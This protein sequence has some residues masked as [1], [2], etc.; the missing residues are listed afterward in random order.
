MKSILIALVLNTFFGFQSLSQTSVTIIHVKGA[1]KVQSTG[2]VLLRGMKISDKESLVYGSLNDM[3]AAIHPEK[4]RVIIQPSSKTKTAGS[5]LAYVIKNIYQPMK[6]SA[7]TRGSSLLSTMGIV[8]YFKA[9]FL[10]LEWN[11]FIFNDQHFPSSDGGFFFVRYQAK[12]YQEP[13]N[14][15]LVW[16]EGKVVLDRSEFLRIDGIAIDPS[17]LSNFELFYFVDG[18]ANKLADMNLYLTS[19]DEIREVVNLFKT[20]GM[21]NPFKECLNFVEITYGNVD[22]TSLEVLFNAE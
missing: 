14:K 22:P 11:E 20:S 7:T 2:K 19:L 15:K 3:V 8:A 18:T 10:V 12:G 6:S 9:G 21:E 13:I 5:E 4:G 16:K 1:V 17:L